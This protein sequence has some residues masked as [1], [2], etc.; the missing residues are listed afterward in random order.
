LIQYTMMNGSISTTSFWDRMV[1]NTFLNM[2]ILLGLNH[3]QDLKVETVPTKFLSGLHSPGNRFLISQFPIL[4]QFPSLT[5]VESPGL[6]VAISML[7]VSTRLMELKTLEH[8]AAESI[9]Y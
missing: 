9:H 2:V 7:L 1:L 6:L 5:W 3:I 4:V 8:L